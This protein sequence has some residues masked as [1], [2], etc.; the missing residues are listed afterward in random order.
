MNMY[1]A[2]TRTFMYSEA[3]VRCLPVPGTQA[4]PYLLLIFSKKTVK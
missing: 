2:L 1:P 3:L 4:D